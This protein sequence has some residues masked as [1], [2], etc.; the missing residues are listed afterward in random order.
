MSCYIQG[1]F[2]FPLYKGFKEKTH[3]ESFISQGTIYLRP[4]SYYRTI[5]DQLRRDKDEGEGKLT[6]LKSRPVISIDKESG[7]R[8]DTKQEIGPVYFSTSSINPRYI[9]CFSG[10]DVNL[11]FLAFKYGNHILRINQ[12]RSLVNDIVSYMEQ[13]LTLYETI[14]LKCLKVRYDKGQMV[15]DFP[16][17]ASEE[18]AELSYCQKS[19]ESQEELESRLVVT[20][21]VGYDRYPTFI[22]IKLNKKLDYVEWV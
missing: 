22:P 11:E 5:E 13:H 8:T 20:I 16:E 10:P 1:S 19:R 21:S 15:E 17:P 12:P 2:D 6:A 9:L 3:A 4:L 7:K 18:R 14:W